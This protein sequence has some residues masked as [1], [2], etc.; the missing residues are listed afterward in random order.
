MRHYI[1]VDG[2]DQK[3]FRRLQGSH[4][5]IIAKES[6]L[7]WWFQKLPVLKQNI[8]L[9][10]KTLPVRGWLIQQIT[11]IAIAHL[12]EE[13]VLIFADSD[14]AFVRPFDPH[15][16]VQEQKVRFFCKERSV[17]ADMPTAHSKWYRNA[18]RLLKTPTVPFPAPAYIS[19]LVTWKRENVL[20]LCRTI[21]EHHHRPWIKVCCNTW[22]LSE[23]ILYGLFVDQVLKDQAGH[24]PDSR[25][26]CHTYWR[27]R[28]MSSSE[29]KNFL[30]DIQ[31]FQVAVM[32]S[33]RANMSPREYS[34][35]LDY[36]PAQ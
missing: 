12:I 10:L 21:E 6:I 26:L 22:H 29:F 34:A 28:P 32:I 23:Y 25:E 24:Y 11:K 30:T 20:K 2:S 16:L 15:T 4:T 13:N 7:P 18:S 27:E 31:P 19:Q 36:T 1:I 3:L 14:V 17:P 9:S 33:S 5:E 35:F 8:W